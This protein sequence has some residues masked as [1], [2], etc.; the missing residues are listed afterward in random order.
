MKLIHIIV[1]T[2]IF[3]AIYGQELTVAGDNHGHSGTGIVFSG[4]PM[5][6]EDYKSDVIRIKEQ[7][8]ERYG[9]EEWRLNVLHKTDREARSSSRIYL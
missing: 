2:M 5:H 9:E 8:I 7:A 1:F 3:K 4:F 6:E